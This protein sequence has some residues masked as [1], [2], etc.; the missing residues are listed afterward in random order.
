[1]AFPNFPLIPN[2]SA[3]LN[4]GDPASVEWFNY[5]KR[6]G[7]ALRDVNANRITLT[8]E[9]Y[10]SKGTYETDERAFAQMAQ[11]TIDLGAKG[12][13]WSLYTGKT[14]KVLGD[15]TPGDQNFVCQVPDTIGLRILRNGARF[16]CN[17]DWAAGDPDTSGF[18]FHFQNPVDLYCDGCEFENTV[19]LAA[20]ITTGVHLFTFGGRAHGVRVGPIDM[21]GGGGAV[22]IDR[23]A[24][25]DN[26]ERG[27]GYFFDLIRTRDVYYSLNTQFNGDGVWARVF[28][29][30]GG[31]SYFNISASYH[32][33]QV[34]VN[35][36]RDAAQLVDIAVGCE[37]GGENKVTNIDVTVGGTHH[38]NV[39]NL[40]FGQE[41]ITSTP[42][43]M[44][45]I[46]VRTRLQ[47]EAS[48]TGGNL[49]SFGKTKSRAAGGGFDNTARGHVA[50]GI[51]IS[52]SCHNV[53]TETQIGA[54]CTDGDWNGE[55]VDIAFRDFAVT[56]GQDLIIDGRGM[57]RLTFDKVRCPSGDLTLTNMAKGALRVD[58]SVDFANFKSEGA[59]GG[60]EYHR[61]GN[62][63]R[64]WGKKTCSNGNANTDVTL[65]VALRS[66]EPDHAVI[67]QRTTGNSDTAAT[68]TSAT[69]LRINRASAAGDHDV[70]WQVIG[71]SDATGSPA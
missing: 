49:V 48:V 11:E 30:N 28:T 7:G 51:E 45:N 35:D 54:I 32:F 40:Q 5:W 61:F 34:D 68:L 43:R 70:D 56:G 18:L 19:E 24:G 16:E 10:G 42:G 67:S 66:G 60:A 25:F 14:Y 46:K 9:R 31:R 62:R 71:Y 47:S 33:I 15:P 12:I 53:D 6:L 36:T 8:P 1:M 21:I 2:Q 69:N 38:G 65:P 44:D 39:V 37:P 23:G 64:Q 29:Q 20:T 3:A 63:V 57:T 59:S 58:G 27:Q 13:T 41:T 55:D 22:F 52:G 26:A 4:G 50:R 17:Y